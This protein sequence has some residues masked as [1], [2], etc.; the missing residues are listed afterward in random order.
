MPAFD[1]RE[2][3]RLPMRELPVYQA[4]EDPVAVAVRYGV[5]PA[6]VLKLDGNE[7]PYGPSPKALEALRGEY[8]PHRYVDPTQARLRDAIAGRLGVSPA[9]VV[10]GAGSDEIIDLLFRL[11]VSEGD[12]VVVATPTFGMY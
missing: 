5:A 3:L 2:A 9:S 7:N 8:A 11:F 12:R 4:L 1:P 6:D 10:A